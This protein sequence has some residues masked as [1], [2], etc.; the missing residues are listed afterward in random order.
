M[1]VSLMQ[2]GPVMFGEVDGIMD[3]LRHNGL[4][5]CSVDLREFPVTTAALDAEINKG[6]A[7]DIPVESVPQHC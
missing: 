1:A 4:L 2:L 3:F 7:I 6:S 5:A